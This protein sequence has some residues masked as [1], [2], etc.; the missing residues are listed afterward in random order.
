MIEASTDRLKLVSR[1]PLDHRSL[2]LV[3]GDQRAG[4]GEGSVVDVVG[5][6]HEDAFF[7]EGRL[8]EA[9]PDLCESSH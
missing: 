7:C 6:Q 1:T 2:N 5:G 8:F 3:G 4:G 9:Y